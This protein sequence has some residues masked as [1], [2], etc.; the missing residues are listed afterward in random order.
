MVGSE[1]H[2]VSLDVPY[3]PDYGGV[4]DIFYKVKALYNVGIGVHL[5]CF[6]YGRGRREELERY[7][8]AV[9]YYPRRT[10]W[11]S[12]LSP[13]PYIVNSRRSHRLL[14][15]LL[16]NDFPILFEGV[17]TT[18]PLLSPGLSGRLVLLRS[19]NVEHEY[20]RQLARRETGLSKKL[21][22]YKEAFSLKRYLKRLPKGMLVGA[23]SPA[24][25]AYFRER[26][27]AT[28]WLPPFH[29]NASVRAVPGKGTYALYHGNLSVSENYE[30]ANRLID[31][32]AGKSIELVVAGKDP[33]PTMIERINSLTNV[34]LIPNPSLYAMHELL[35]DAHV[36]LLPTNQAT[37]IK[38]KLLESLHRGRFCLANRKMIERTGLEELVVSAE[39]N[40]YALTERYFSTPFTQREIERR[41]KLIAS[42]YDNE[43]NAL[44]IADKLGL[45]RSD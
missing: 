6:D 7:C 35:Q 26:F 18:Q 22:F 12:H 33:L 4:L 25:A 34:R 32:F 45:S 21:Y 5:H 37:G 30:V 31:E 11:L 8:S 16:E 19:H 14:D 38:L 13:L 10:G 43:A 23:I 2:I 44:L 27:E 36:V 40:F 39:E 20:Y 41:A 24:D 42:H 9:Y 3:P 17:H 15:R 1:L 29:S 28:F